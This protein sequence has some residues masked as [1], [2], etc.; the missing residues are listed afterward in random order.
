MCAGEG[1]VELAAL[2]DSEDRRVLVLG[3]GDRE[4]REVGE[5]PRVGDVRAPA[6]G[7]R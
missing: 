6:C 7:S 4:R 2:G 3:E 1:G 5:R